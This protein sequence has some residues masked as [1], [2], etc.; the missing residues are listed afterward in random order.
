VPLSMHIPRCQ[1]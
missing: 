1:Q